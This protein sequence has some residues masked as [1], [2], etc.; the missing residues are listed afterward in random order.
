MSLVGTIKVLKGTKKGSI[1]LVGTNFYS[2]FYTFRW[3][4]SR[5]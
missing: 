4:I 1:K 3:F 5:Y 2:R